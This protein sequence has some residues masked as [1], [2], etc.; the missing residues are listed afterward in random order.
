M[1]LALQAGDVWPPEELC[2]LGDS[3]EQFFVCTG[4]GVGDREAG[5]WLRL[6][7][8]QLSGAAGSPAGWQRVRG[9]GSRAL[10]RSTPV[11]VGRQL[12]WT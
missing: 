2:A 7:A 6:G 12:A 1:Y 3:Q 11:Q 10:H 8:P 5:D 4:L 9:R